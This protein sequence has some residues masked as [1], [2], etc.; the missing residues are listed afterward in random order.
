MT[1]ALSDEML[2]RFSQGLAVVP[3]PQA[4]LGLLE[5]ALYGFL[6]LLPFNGC[7]CAR[8]RAK[9]LVLRV[10]M[11]SAAAHGQSRL[12]SLGEGAKLLPSASA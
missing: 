1:I 12:H 6:W 7:R 10:E 5:G 4:F 3:P 9:D 11:L 8:T 2:D